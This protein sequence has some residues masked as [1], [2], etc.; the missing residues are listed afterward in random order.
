MTGL[1]EDSCTR[2]NYMY[3]VIM[4]SV[5]VQDDCTIYLLLIVVGY[6]CMPST[7]LTLVKLSFLKVLWVPDLTDVCWRSM[8]HVWSAVQRPKQ[9]GIQRPSGLALLAEQQGKRLPEITE[10]VPA[11]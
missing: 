7:L 3:V 2:H 8:L 9:P 5:F 11:P 6:T 10:L 4:I 1:L